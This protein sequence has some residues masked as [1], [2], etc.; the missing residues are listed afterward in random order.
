MTD[1]LIIG[2]YMPDIQ[3]AVDVLRERGVDAIAAEPPRPDFYPVCGDTADIIVNVVTDPLVV[4][5]HAVTWPDQ[6]FIDAHDLHWR[7]WK[8][9]RTPFDQHV[10]AM[11]YWYNWTRGCTRVA[12]R[13][14]VFEEFCGEFLNDVFG[15]RPFQNVT[16]RDRT[17]TWDTLINHHERTAA[18]VVT[19]AREWG[20][21]APIVICP[22]CGGD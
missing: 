3:A 7:I 21:D 5:G 6:F 19:E 13:S 1:V 15:L 8:V 2:T 10:R 12:D 14:V 22:T 4:I 20:W 17:L 11:Q 9:G 16:H 18:A